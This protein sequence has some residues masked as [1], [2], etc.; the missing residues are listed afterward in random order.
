VLVDLN[1]KS[2]LFFPEREPHQLCMV[3]LPGQGTF[4]P[5]PIGL[6]QAAL[7]QEHVGNLVGTYLPLPTA[8]QMNRFLGFIPDVRVYIAVVGLEDSGWMVGVGVHPE[9][10]SASGIVLWL[11][12]RGSSP[13]TAANT[14]PSAWERLLREDPWSS[15]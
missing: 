14:G 13:E 8:G 7:P 12:M 10:S 15:T 3:A 2:P 5:C 11:H 9:K 4:H 6:L 1:H